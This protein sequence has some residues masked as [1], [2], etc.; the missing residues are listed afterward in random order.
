MQDV[1]NEL[2]NTKLIKLR[3]CRCN[4]LFDVCSV[5]FHA[6]LKPET[7]HVIVHGNKTFTINPKNN[8]FFGL[9][10][11][12][13]EKQNNFKKQNDEHRKEVNKSYYQKEGVKEKKREREQTVEYKEKKKIYQAKYRSTEE[14]KEYQTKYRSTEEYKEKQKE[15]RSTEE[16]KE[17]QKEYRSRPDVK[18]RK[19]KKQNERQQ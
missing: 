19:N 16:Y 6:K 4:I 5:G 2:K 13:R 3:K 11:R 17:K 8:K 18:E 10:E 14:Y 9:C 1:M 12:C 7:G 15:Y